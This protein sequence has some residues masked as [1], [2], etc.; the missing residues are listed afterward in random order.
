MRHA[1]LRLFNASFSLPRL[2]QVSSHFML[3]KGRLLETCPRSQSTGREWVAESNP[4]L[5]D[6]LTLRRWHW[7]E[8]LGTA[9]TMPTGVSNIPRLLLLFLFLLFANPESINFQTETSLQFCT[10]CAP[11]FTRKWLQVLLRHNVRWHWI[12][13]WG[14]P[15]VPP[16]QSLHPGASPCGARKSVPPNTCPSFHLNKDAAAD[17]GLHQVTACR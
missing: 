10:T 9:W 5:P 6:T 11:W 4:G 7:R 16:F 2:E 3:W 13:Q 15:Q 8:V 14:A 1:Q 12:T 17:S